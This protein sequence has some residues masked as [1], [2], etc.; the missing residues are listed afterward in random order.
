MKVG[1]NYQSL[2]LGTSAAPQ[3]FDPDN[4]L[5]GVRGHDTHRA[6]GGALSGI[7][8]S[9]SSSVHTPPA[10]AADARRFGLWLDSLGRDK[11]YVHQ[12]LSD[13]KNDDEKRQL[14]WWTFAPDYSSALLGGWFCWFHELEQVFLIV[15]HLEKA[16]PDD[17]HVIVYRFGEMKTVKHTRKD[18]DRNG[19]DILF[20]TKL[21]KDRGYVEYVSTDLVGKSPRALSQT[22]PLSRDRATDSVSLFLGVEAQE[23]LG[24]GRLP[25]RF[26]GNGI[27]LYEA[28]AEDFKTTH[29]LF[30]QLL[31]IEFCECRRRAVGS[32]ACPSPE[33]AK[34]AGGVVEFRILT[35]ERNGENE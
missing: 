21:K 22:A 32:P 17:G 8:S 12:K 3:N 30:L 13:C 5:L 23:K 19:Q 20:D 11:H 25:H 34:I 2:M 14:A 4:D 16:K 35:H 9:T 26:E 24:D 29:K 27:K 6:V 18:Y 7:G 33:T 1:D 31:F 28:S 10:A 15:P